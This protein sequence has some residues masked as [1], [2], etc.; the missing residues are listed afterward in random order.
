MTE[1]K[2]NRRQAIKLAATAAAVPAVAAAAV[3]LRL[4]PGTHQMCWEDL[5][6]QQYVGESITI[7]H[8]FP[9]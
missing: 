7:G 9:C 3:P 5:E 2:I 4:K 6:P 8:F 1:P